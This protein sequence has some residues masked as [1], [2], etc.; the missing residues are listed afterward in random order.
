[1]ANAFRY[2]KT[3]TGRYN[4]EKTP[5]IGVFFK[6]LFESLML[7]EVV[8]FRFRM[9]A[10]RGACGEPSRRFAPLE[11]SPVPLLPQESRTLHSNQLF[12]EENEKINQK[13]KSFR[14]QAFLMNY[15]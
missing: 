12:N 4:D 11:V 7:L 3:E 5:M 13:Q 2:S 1:M 8:D 6:S 10:F 14:K 15:G 9:L